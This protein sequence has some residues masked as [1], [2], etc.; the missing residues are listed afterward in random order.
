M[1]VLYFL[2][3]T[4]LFLLNGKLRS[5]TSEYLGFQ[6]D[7]TWISSNMFH[8]FHQWTFTV[9][10]PMNLFSN[11]NTSILASIF[12]ISLVFQ[13]YCKGYQ[14]TYRRSS[15]TTTRA[16]CPSDGGGVQYHGWWCNPW[17]YIVLR[18]GCSTRTKYVF[19]P[20]GF[21][22]HVVSNSTTYTGIF[23]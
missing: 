18:I 11:Q 20:G 3:W 10:V 14:C 7:E 16:K 6:V 17:E 23:I 19:I 4:L 15:W 21:A 22:W 5:I 8:T 1:N 12:T 13:G 9:T 2:G